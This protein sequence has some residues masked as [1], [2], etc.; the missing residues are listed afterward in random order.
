[1]WGG[2]NGRGKGEWKRLRW[3]YVVDGLCIPIWNKTMKPL[4][5]VLKWG[6]RG[7]KGQIIGEM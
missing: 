6:G 7:L 1:V 5:I 2:T 3:G 4:A